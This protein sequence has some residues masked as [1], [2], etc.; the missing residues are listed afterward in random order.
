MKMRRW[1][2]IV[3]LGKIILC[4]EDIAEEDFFDI[5]RLDASLFDGSFEDV[6]L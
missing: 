3:E 1:F 2:E 6:S 4:G 5:G